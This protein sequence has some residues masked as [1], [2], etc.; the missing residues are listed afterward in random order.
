MIAEAPRVNVPLLRKTLE[1]IEAH[2]EEWDQAHWRCGTVMCFAGTACHLDGGEWVGD[3]PVLLQRDGEPDDAVWQPSI[4]QGHVHVVTRARRIL[5]LTVGQSLCLFSAANDLGDLR[6][7]VA[8]LCEA[9][10]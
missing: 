9:G 1:H 7:W 2:P 10:Q 5:G 6:R 8:A 3:L 4:G